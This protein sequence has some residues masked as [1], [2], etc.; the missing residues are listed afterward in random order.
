MKSLKERQ[1]QRAHHAAVYSGEIV[2]PV[3]LFGTDTP[4]AAP[5]VSD[6]DN[7]SNINAVDNS[8]TDYSKLGT[9]AELDA[10]LGTRTKPDGWDGFKVADK[11]AWLVANPA[12]ASAW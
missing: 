1:K 11:Q 5:A 3:I 2:D 6:T 9:H 4:N 12:T 7:G 8:P 10:A